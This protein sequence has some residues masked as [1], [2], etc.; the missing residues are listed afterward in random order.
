VKII[1]PFGA[2]GPADVTA[3]LLAQ[4]LQ[5]KLKQPFVVEDKPSAGAVIGTIEVARAA[6]DG[7]TLLMMSNTQTANES[8]LPGRNYALMRDFVAI[9]PVN[10]SDLVIV[11]HPSV[12]AR[13]LT[14]FIALAKSEPGLLDIKVAKGSAIRTE[15]HPRFY[16]DGTG[17]VPIAVPAL[18]RN[19]WPMLFFCVFKAPTEGQTHIFRPNE[20][21][22]QIIVIPE[23]AN[24]ELVEMDAEEAAERELQARRIY[25]NRPTLSGE[26][27]W[28]SSTN[29]VFDGTY[30]HLHRAAKDQERKS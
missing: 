11:V 14:D 20:P 29:T 4:N 3:R 9:A 26:T 17:T 27:E 12:P 19:W 2:G 7:Y 5:D 16:T 25:A 21:F 22:A 8:L 30:R 10:T 23:E 28:L 18:I 15:P 24:F 6:P 13:T 1:V